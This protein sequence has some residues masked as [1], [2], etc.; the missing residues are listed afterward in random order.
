MSLSLPRSRF[1][2][3]L[4]L[5]AIFLV[6][7]LPKIARAQ[8]DAGV[9]DTL[10][11]TI[12]RSRFPDGIRFDISIAGS[13]QIVDV[14]LRYRVLGERA[15]RY[16]R[17]QFEPTNRLENEFLVRT[18]TSPRYIPPGAEIEY[19]LEITDEDG[20]LTETKPQRFILL[21]P[22]FQ[23]QR[24]DSPGGYIYYHGAQRD[25]AQRVL[26]AA[27]STLTTMGDLMGVT[28]TGPLRMTM[29]NGVTE[30]RVALPFTSAVQEESLITEGVSFGDTGVILVL[31]SAPRVE[32]VTSHETVH[33]LVRHATGNLS[34]IVPAWLNEG[35]AEYGNVEPSGSYD[36]ALDFRLSEGTLLPLTS[37]TTVPGKPEDVIL[38]YGEARS[39]VAYMVDTYG[40]G[41]LQKLLEGMRAGLGIDDALTA[42]YGFD[43]TGLE[44]EWRVSI[45][46]PA[47]VATPSRSALPTAIPR[48]TLVPFGVATPTASAP[49][50]QF[51][52]PPLPSPTPARSGGCGRSYGHAPIDIAGPATLLLLGLLAYGSR[53]W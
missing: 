17:L 49:S 9:S 24:L 43:R 16:G 46:A 38:M 47:L 39:V 29:Y 14:R 42:A 35:L 3:L 23:W 2:L 8:E 11:T 31:G 30:M 36:R 1:G 28:D 25:R 51:V 32:G 34:R 13:R 33:F 48:P 53:R 5:S 21:D 19:A 37:L 45:G 7:L 6:L 40:A 20:L 27:Q 26:D 50:P 12:V 52:D 10:I 15:T 18:D 41:L 22:R 4:I 44:A